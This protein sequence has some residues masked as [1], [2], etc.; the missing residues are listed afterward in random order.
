MT[1][2]VRTV[3]PVKFAHV[4]FRT[5]D[6]DRLVE[7]YCTVLN[8]HV[9]MKNDFIAFLT[10]DD[11]HHRVAMVKDPRITEADPAVERPGVDHVSYTYASLE[12]LVATY[13]RLLELGITPYWTV[14]HG[15]TTSLYYR[16]PDGNQV[17]LQIDNFDSVEALNDYFRSGAFNDNPIGVN[18]DVNDLVARV[19]AGSN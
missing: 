6:L 4:V 8:A 2:P 14:D 16:D 19:H 15:P 7:W 18:I 11:E 10:Y 12:D 3:A 5:P 9:A 13:E 17:E 1:T